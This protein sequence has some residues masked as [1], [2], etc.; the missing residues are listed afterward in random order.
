[1]LCFS[2]SIQDLILVVAGCLI[3]F[4][5]SARLGRGHL[6]DHPI[7]SRSCNWSR[8]IAQCKKC[9]TNKHVGSEEIWLAQISL[10]PD[11]V[12]E[13]SKAAGRTFHIP[14]MGTFDHDF[15][16]SIGNFIVI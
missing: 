6:D 3:L 5:R 11:P 15:N 2:W 12:S 4:H 9:L 10:R 13:F 8:K 1:M 7:C 16:S 14:C